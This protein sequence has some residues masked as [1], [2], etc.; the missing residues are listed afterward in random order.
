MPK[1]VDREQYRKELLSKCF[2][3]FAQHSY[4]SITMRQIAQGL[5]VSTGTLY[6]YFPS[7]ESL[8]EQLVEYL[9]YEDTAE[10]KVAQ[11]G[12][13]PTVGDR[14]RALMQFVAQNED[15]FRQQ[16]LVLVD[17]SQHR[18]AKTESPSLI[19]E[20]AEE[21]YIQAICNFLGIKNPQIAIHL[22]TLCDGLLLKR[23][24]HRDRVSL[25][26]QGELLAQMITAYL[27]KHPDQESV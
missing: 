4:G 12:N 24:I 15:Y 11:L 14:V 26:E 6:H 10:Q 17:Y 5:G 9:S 23:L 21:R 22:C 25:T 20:Q 18:D 19:L 16:L 13:P 7:K 8:F 1:I 3:L 27:E 2:E